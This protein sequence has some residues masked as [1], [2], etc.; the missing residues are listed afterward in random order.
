MKLT[1]NV[2]KARQKIQNR[3]NDAA[4]T[5]NKKIFSEY[6]RQNSQTHKI[7]PVMPKELVTLTGL[8]FLECLRERNIDQYL[9]IA[10]YRSVRKEGQEIKTRSS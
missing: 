9:A 10:A 1:E 7:V 2:P 5:E 4:G 8:A 3:G 6:A